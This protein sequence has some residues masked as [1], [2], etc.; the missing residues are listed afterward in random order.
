MYE[1]AGRKT[2]VRVSLLLC[3]VDLK[4]LIGP[5]LKDDFVD[6]FLAEGE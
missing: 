3:V 5:T 1:E 6:D 4:R 2:H